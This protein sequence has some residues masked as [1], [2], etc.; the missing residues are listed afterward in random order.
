MPFHALGRKFSTVFHRIACGDA[1]IDHV[2]EPQKSSKLPPLP[3]KDERA[4]PM[5]KAASKE[6][7][8]S[9]NEHSTSPLRLAWTQLVPNSL[10]F[11]VDPSHPHFHQYQSLIDYIRSTHSPS[12]LTNSV[13]ATWRPLSQQHPSFGT[14]VNLLADRY[15]LPE[16]SIDSVNIGLSPSS[17]LDF[18]LFGLLHVVRESR[19]AAPSGVQY[20]ATDSVRG[21]AHGAARHMELYQAA[22]LDFLRPM[23]EY[24]CRARREMKS[25]P[26][27]WSRASKDDKPRLEHASELAKVPLPSEI[28]SMGENHPKLQTWRTQYGNPLDIPWLGS[29]HDDYPFASTLSSYV[30]LRRTSTTPTLRDDAALWLG[31][32]TFGLTE[33]VTRTKV[34]ETDILSPGTS[35]GTRVASGARLSSL[36][37]KWHHYMQ[38][39]MHRGAFDPEAHH[40]RGCE[41]VPVLNQVLAALDEEGLQ[42]TSLMLRAGFSLD[43]QVDIL[44]ALALAIGTLFNC[45]LSIWRDVPEMQNI[46]KQLHD[47]TRYFHQHPKE[48][49]RRVMLSA[50]WCP[51]SVSKRFLASINE[52][53]LL[54]H[55]VR[56]KPFVRK[57]EDEHSKCTEAGCALYTIDLT[58]Y[59]VRHVDPT[60]HCANAAPPLQ[61]IAKLLSSSNG[62]PN[63]VPVVHW[64]GMQLRVRPAA[65]GQYVAISH[66]WADGLGS[67]TEVG[68]PACQIAR[69][70]ELVKQ[71]VPGTGDFWMDSL[72][73]PREAALRTR[74]LKLLPKTYREAAKVLVL[75]ECVRARCAKNKPWEE[76]L[77][78][79]VMSGWA[80]RVWT[81]QEAV[82][83]KRLS[84]EYA[85]GLADVTD[86]LRCINGKDSSVPRPSGSGKVP[87]D[88]GDG[89]IPNGLEAHAFNPASLYRS[90]FPVITLRSAHKDSLDGWCTI[91]EVIDLLR[92]RTVTKREDEIISLSGLLPIDVDALLSLNGPDAA[93]QRMRATLQKLR[94]LPRRL[95]M[96]HTSR[97][98]LPEFRWAP[99]SFTGAHEPVGGTND[100]A[101]C[102][103]EGL[104]ADYSFARFE[105][106]VAIPPFCAQGLQEGF[107]IAIIQQGSACI[108][109]AIF[110]M[111]ADHYRSG[112]SGLPL[113]V[114]GLIFIHDK[115]PRD[116]RII[117]C[118]AVA[119]RTGSAQ[120]EGVGNSAVKCDYVASV[121]FWCSSDAGGAVEPRAHAIAMTPDVYGLFTIGG[122]SNTKVLLR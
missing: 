42:G 58:T 71:I 66:V 62:G 18:I 47:T 77:F 91:D 102:T 78:R 112:V 63:V 69:L 73:V 20:F 8:S 31:A 51:Y 83:A 115:L 80:R 22:L 35:G 53:A 55:I 59:S 100:T 6:G 93:E 13:F 60:C 106:S 34:S 11:F 36:L 64:D 30:K 61:H 49:C 29:A 113:S 79:I 89:H 84:F 48:M 24:E 9:K 7:T 16:E 1:D 70:A 119:L 3:P 121:E 96:L 97:L 38:D 2:Q 14:L 28:E 109:E 118:A 68:L 116:S 10:E 114:D 94:D 27:P 67:T 101:V 86:Q 5:S 105:S 81:A 90:C 21:R 72:C 4:G 88:T 87:L 45:A 43:A 74:A 46:S 95:P 39:F 65:D 23:W 92:L 120:G 52:L 32:M 57:A 41:L 33:I 56:G 104:S 19:R 108:Y 122:L 75:D 110:S 103:S 37:F 12:S 17:T 99:L 54:S 44:G 98:N 76:N 50:G 15:S 82:L 107:K 26:M 40:R 85:D 111:P 117:A 25:S